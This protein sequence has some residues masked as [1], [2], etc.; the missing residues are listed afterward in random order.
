M[1]P[2]SSRESQQTLPEDVKHGLYCQGEIHS[3]P[4]KPKTL[5][6][7]IPNLTIKNPGFLQKKGVFNQ[8]PPKGYQNKN[9][10]PA[11]GAGSGTKMVQMEDFLV[12]TGTD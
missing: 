7:K 4:I 9:P 10:N 12:R 2:K 3:F 5:P 6:K 8:T 11:D 1:H